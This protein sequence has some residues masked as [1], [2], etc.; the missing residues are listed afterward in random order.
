MDVTVL[1]PSGQDDECEWSKGRVPVV[2]S[3]GDGWFW[4]GAPRP[5]FGP[6]SRCGD[7]QENPVTYPFTSYRGDVTFT[8]PQLGERPVDFN[9]EG[10]LHLGL[11][12]ELIED[13]R[14]DGMTD[15]DL[16]PLFRSA[17]GYLRMWEK[18]ETRAAALRGE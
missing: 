18:A 13:A 6:D 5:R 17:E 3:T 15:E 11:V 16:E 1:G 9:N 2:G 14:R 10:M 7:G 12:A 8:E 4:P